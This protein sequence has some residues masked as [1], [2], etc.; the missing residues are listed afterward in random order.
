MKTFEQFLE[1]AVA[2]IPLE[3]QYGVKMAL[4]RAKNQ[5]DVTRKV[6]AA[7]PTHRMPHGSSQHA[8]YSENEDLGEMVIRSSVDG[9]GKG[10]PLHALDPI[11]HLKGVA[12]HSK[13]A[14]LLRAKEHPDMDKFNDDEALQDAIRYHERMLKAHSYLSS[15]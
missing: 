12:Y 3:G 2:R 15:K 4:K 10:K 14:R 11:T 8:A 5:S 9:P 7:N 6:R 13:E 1:A